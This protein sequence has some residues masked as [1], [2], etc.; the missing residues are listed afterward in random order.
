MKRLS[1]KPTP[2]YDVSRFTYDFDKGEAS[3]ID[4]FT[5]IYNVCK[6]TFEFASLSK[7]E[8]SSLS[9]KLWPRAEG[10]EWEWEAVGTTVRV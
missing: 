1:I 9:C 2:S 4:S 5:S 6:F 8:A 3:L 10:L 7:G